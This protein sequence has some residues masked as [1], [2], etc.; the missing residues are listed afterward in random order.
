[1]LKIAKTGAAANVIGGYTINDGLCVDIANPSGITAAKQAHLRKILEGVK[2][3]IVDEVSL[4]PKS[5][6]NAIDTALRAAF[7][8]NAP[9]G[10][11]HII[12]VGC[13]GKL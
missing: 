12:F 9:W 2:L 8:M 5:D 3:V 7:N 6:L 1:V 10:G 11:I 13:V 4:C